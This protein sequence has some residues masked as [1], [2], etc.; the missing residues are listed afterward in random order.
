MA[1]E[2]DSTWTALESGDIDEL[3]EGAKTDLEPTALEI[4]DIEEDD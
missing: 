1:D 4:V 2:P 3:P